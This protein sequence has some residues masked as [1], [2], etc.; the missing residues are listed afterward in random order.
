[1]N[2][3]AV[4]MKAAKEWKLRPSE[5]GLCGPDDDITYMVAYLRAE[6][7]MAAWE[8]QEAEREAKWQGKK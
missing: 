5:L 2:L 1:M 7:N 8:Q 6:S 3:R 4:L